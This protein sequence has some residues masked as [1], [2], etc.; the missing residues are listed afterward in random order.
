[1]G[2][3]ETQCTSRAWP[4]CLRACGCLIK[5]TPDPALRSTWS[6]KYVSPHG[7]PCAIERGCVASLPQ[8]SELA[9]PHHTPLCIQTLTAK[10]A[11]T[12]LHAQL[13]WWVTSIASQSSWARQA[14][15]STKSHVG[16]W[17]LRQP[18]TRWPI[19]I[20]A[21]CTR[22]MEMRAHHPC[23]KELIPFPAPSPPLSLPPSRS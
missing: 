6:P 8:S 2:P 16:P 14:G 5:R 17:S 23:P 19:V 3:H 22:R 7:R 11:R 20:D 13:R 21:S 9:L 15:A 18:C 12:A 10:G 1:M 4:W